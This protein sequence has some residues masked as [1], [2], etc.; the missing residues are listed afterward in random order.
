MGIIAWKF[1]L[2]TAAVFALFLYRGWPLKIL[3]VNLWDFSR[4]ILWI[5]S[6]AVRSL[7]HTSVAK[8][9]FSSGLPLRDEAYEVPH[10]HKWLCDDVVDWNIFLPLKEW[11]G[12]PK[13]IYH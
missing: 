4:A 8:P 6:L 12:I 1:L 5:T 13:H 7:A 11:K 2:P 3:A 9:I 10:H